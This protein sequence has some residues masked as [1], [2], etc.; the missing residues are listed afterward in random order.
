MG[1]VLMLVGK[2]AFFV[3]MYDKGFKNIAQVLVLI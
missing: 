3:K 2:L 1:D